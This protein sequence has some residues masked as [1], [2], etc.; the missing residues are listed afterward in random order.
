MKTCDEYQLAFEMS[1]HGALDVREGE[2]A[3]RHVKTCPVCQREVARMEEL[4]RA[5]KA[6]PASAPRYAEV[7]QALAKE[8]FWFKYGPWIALA[9]FVGQGAV[10][11]P[12]LRPDAPL[13]LWATVSAVGVV[14]AVGLAL[15]LRGL[16]RRA[17]EAAQLGVDAWMAHRRARIDAELKDLGKLM[18]LFPALSVAMVGVALLLRP[19]SQAGFILFLLCAGVNLAMT[20]YGALARKPRLL[21][22]RA[23]LEASSC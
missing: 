10:L 8:R 18:W 3:E 13:K 4:D 15:T 23:E 11:G 9:S 14:F 20:A 1:R 17:S 16:R 5:L 6:P 7:S 12:L 22:E 19:R 2:E 21:R